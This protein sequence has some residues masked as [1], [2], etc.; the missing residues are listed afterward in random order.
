LIFAGLL[1]LV[2]GHLVGNAIV[3]SLVTAD[4]V[5]PA[6]TAAWSIGTSLLREMAIALVI[7]GSVAL[8]GAWLA[9]RTRPAVA[10]RRMLSP[11][12]GAQPGIVF[13]VVAFVYLL[14]VLWGP[15][16]ALERWWGI[17]IFGGLVF[18]GVEM[19]RRQIVAESPQP[20]QPVAT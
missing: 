10:I 17:L 9:G 19:L 5:Q 16:P 7:Y 2:L 13:G 15:T 8:A 1:I 6:A 3:N 20:A 11:R 14:V 12:F 18:L 4:A